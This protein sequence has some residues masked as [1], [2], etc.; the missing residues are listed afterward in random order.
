LT[1]GVT[2]AAVD[3]TS[4]RQSEANFSFLAELTDA[5]MRAGS[6]REVARIAAERIAEPC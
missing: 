1:V 3:L 5:L 4:R 6:P 2:C